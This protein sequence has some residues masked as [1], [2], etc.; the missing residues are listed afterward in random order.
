MVAN[1]SSPSKGMSAINRTYRKRPNLTHSSDNLSLKTVLVL[2]SASE[3]V[4]SSTA[5]PN[6]V[7]Y[8]SDM[9]EHVSTCKEKNCD[10][11]DGGPYV[12]VLDDGE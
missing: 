12:A 5:I 6:N 8:L 1:D 7:R 2:E 9:I 11:T 10:K 3:V 4:D